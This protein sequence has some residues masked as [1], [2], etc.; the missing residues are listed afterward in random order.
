M[1]MVENW[2]FKP[3]VDAG[4]QANIGNLT[5]DLLTYSPK[6]ACKMMVFRK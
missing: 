2:E 4:K 6:M 5:S 1:K 3:A